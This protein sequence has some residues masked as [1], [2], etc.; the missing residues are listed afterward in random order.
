MA[1]SMPFSKPDQDPPSLPPEIVR[2]ALL[3]VLDAGG[4]FQSRVDVM[5]SSM[6]CKSWYL[7]ARP[8]VSNDELFRKLELKHDSFSDS[9]IDVLRLV[10]LLLESKRLGLGDYQ[11]IQTIHL[12]IRMDTAE[13]GK[14]IDS[15]AAIVAM[16][17]PNLRYLVIELECQVN[18]EIQDIRCFIDFFDR[19]EPLCVGI[20]SVELYGIEIPT[21]T[22]N[23]RLAE[24]VAALSPHLEELKFNAIELDV[25]LRTALGRCTDLRR[26]TFD[27]VSGDCL[28]SELRLLKNLR[29]LCFAPPV[30]VNVD[31]SLIALGLH[32]PLLEDFTLIIRSFWTLSV[33]EEPMFSD[34]S[35]YYLLSCCP[36]IK[37]LSISGAFWLGDPFLTVLWRHGP[38]LERIELSTCLVITGLAAVTAMGQEGGG[39]PE[40]RSLELDDNPKLSGVFVEKVLVLCPKLELVLLPTNLCKDEHCI[41]ML[42]GYGFR[43]PDDLRIWKKEN[44]RLETLDRG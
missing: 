43:G 2:Q 27:D 3:Y 20:R 37:I 6:V 1:L 5:A 22:Y 40:L 12:G 14:L 44:S 21:E 13:P 38:A 39:W 7:E 34:S 18:P 33:P 30:S 36:N 35:L 10:D 28:P 19:I 31:Q 11:L 15:F 4:W 17:P 8:L 29:Q 32:C 24:F 23:V 9:I 16:K 26:V 41:K 42:E 25:P